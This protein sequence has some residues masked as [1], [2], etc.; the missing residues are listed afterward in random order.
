MLF[1]TSNEMKVNIDLVMN[2]N[3]DKKGQNDL[4]F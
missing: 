1:M 3:N 2:K 4:I